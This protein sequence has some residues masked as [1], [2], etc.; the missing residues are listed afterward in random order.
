M[1]MKITLEDYEITKMGEVINLKTGRILKPQPNNK[2][3]LRVQL[4]GKRYFVHRLVAEKYLPNP[5]NLEQVNHKDG[6]KTN[7]NVENLEWVS[8]E[9]N[10][11]HAVKSGL[12]LSGE[13]CSWSKLNWDKVNF[14]RENPQ[15]SAKELAETFGVSVSTIRDVKNYKIW[16]VI[17][18][19]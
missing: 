6:N 7:N 14:I 8:N 5:N 13:K 17:N 4:C 12:L 2:G 11:I 15:I 18:N 16:K 10:H 9:T 19:S 3:Y 1:G